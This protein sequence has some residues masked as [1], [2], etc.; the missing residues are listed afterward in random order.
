[1]VAKY[2]RPW[3]ERNS[4]ATRWLHGTDIYIN[5]IHSS[6]DIQYVVACEIRKSYYFWY[7]I[8]RYFSLLRN[9]I[10]FLGMF[11]I[12]RVSTFFLLIDCENSERSAAEKHIHNKFNAHGQE[13]KAHEKL[14]DKHTIRECVNNVVPRIEQLRKFIS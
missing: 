14:L 9:M 10:Y 7:K 13:S 4:M 12:W 6:I 8:N 11:G 3:I 2:S 1:M 5:K